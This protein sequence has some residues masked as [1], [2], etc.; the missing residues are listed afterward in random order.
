MVAN[1]VTA[2]LPSQIRIPPGRAENPVEFVLPVFIVHK[3]SFFFSIPLAEGLI[4][5]ALKDVSAF[6]SIYLTNLK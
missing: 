3:A 4:N 1:L 6:E 2:K 5:P